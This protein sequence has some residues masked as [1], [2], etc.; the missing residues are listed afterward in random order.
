MCRCQS[1][2]KAKSLNK[3]NP[4]VALR[5]NNSDSKIID[6]LKKAADGLLCMSESDYPFEVFLWESL[7]KEELTTEKLLEQTNHPKDTP[8]EV[9]DCDYFFETATQEQDWHGPE[10]KE[11]VK[12]YQNLFKTLKECLT[13]LKVYRVGTINIDVYIVGISPSRNLTGLSTKLV[14]T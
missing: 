10:E 13:D 9:E 5:M 12:K 3:Q 4:F 1:A 14:E 6:T 11:T 8:V 2:W 7:G